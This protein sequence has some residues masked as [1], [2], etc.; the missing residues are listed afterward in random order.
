MKQRVL[1]GSILFAVFLPILIWGNH[2]YLFD[3]T[4]L[5]LCILASIELVRLFQHEKALP[6]VVEVFSVLLSALVYLA[7]LATTRYAIGSRVLILALLVII[8]VNSLLLVFVKDYKASDFGNQLTIILYSSLGFA[9]LA[10]LRHL[11]LE[12]IIYLFM[13]AMITDTAAYFFGIR[14]GK[15]KLAPSVSPKKSVEGAVW[16]LIFGGTLAAAFALIVNL[17]EPNF[18]IPFIFIISYGL[19]F[20]AQLGDLVASKLKRSYQVK[21]FSNLFPGHGGILDRFDSSLLA[22]L[23]LI[24]IQAFIQGF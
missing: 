9:A 23:F 2:F 13:T 11:S 19:S 15:H 12:W 21:D 22:A 4:A 14:F 3:L 1:T 18:P 16:G 6:K 24:V 20:I 10:A 8:M 7:L 17:F 5:V